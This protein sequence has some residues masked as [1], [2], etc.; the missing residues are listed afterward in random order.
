MGTLLEIIAILTVTTVWVLVMRG[1]II[2]YKKNGQGKNVP[3]N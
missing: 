2:N 3:K 1:L